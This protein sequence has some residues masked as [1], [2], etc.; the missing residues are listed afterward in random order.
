MRLKFKKTEIGGCYIIEPEIFGDNRGVLRRH[1]DSDTFKSHGIDGRVRQ[2]NIS[3]NS[4]KYTLRGF[5]YQAGREARTVSCVRGRIHDIVVDLRPKS[6][7]FL[8]W[9]AFVLSDENR[10]S[11]HPPSGCANA[12]LT[13][14]PNTIVHYYHSEKYSPKAEK[15]IRYNDP[16]FK[17]VWP[18]KPEVMSEKDKSWP[19]FKAFSFS[20]RKSKSA[21]ATKGGL[22]HREKKTGRSE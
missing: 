1:F 19:D 2:C 20:K 15:G 12:F 3:E 14:E 4:A 5:H 10:L 11:L 6:K 9:S 13:L 7:T 22:F 16:L 21:K 17:F 8:R 18:H